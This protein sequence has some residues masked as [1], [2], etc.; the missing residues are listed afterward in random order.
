[1]LARTLKP[2]PRYLLIVLALAGDSTMTSFCP[3][4]GAPPSGRAAVLGLRVDLRAGLSA[5]LVGVAFLRL[6][7]AGVVFLRLPLAGGAGASADC[8]LRA[9]T[10]LS[11]L[12]L[13][14]LED[15]LQ[16]TI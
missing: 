11:L 12:L 16:S 2:G 1:M 14:S 4:R 13:C 9:G 7:L 6:L 10:G 3:V 15:S 8:F 5:P